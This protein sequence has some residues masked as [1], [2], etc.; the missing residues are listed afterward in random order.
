MVE[1]G[2][3]SPNTSPWTRPTASPTEALV[4]NIRVRTTCSRPPP[5]SPIAVRM[6]SRHR[7]AWAAGS[8]SQEPS[9]QIGAVPDTSTRSPTRTARQ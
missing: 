5:A 1:T 7:R 4:T 3:T 6:I 2:R 9:G 8:G